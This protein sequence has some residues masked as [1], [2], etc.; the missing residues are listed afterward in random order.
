MMHSEAAIPATRK[1]SPFNN[2]NPKNIW[3]ISAGGGNPE[4]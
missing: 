3:R 2:Q 4:L 1:I